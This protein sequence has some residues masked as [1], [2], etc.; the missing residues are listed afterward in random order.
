MPLSGSLSDR[1]FRPFVRW[2]ASRL[3]ADFIR[4]SISAGAVLLATG[5]GLA[6]AE[7]ALLWPLDLDPA[8]SSTF[9]ETR[10]TAFHAGID[11]KTWGRTGFEVRAVASGHV[12]R[13][14]TSPWGF[15]RAVYQKLRDG[16]IAVYAHLESFSPALAQRVRAAQ[17]KAGRYTVDLWLKEGELP[18]AR[19]EVIARSGESGAG[20]PHLHLEIRNAGNVP[21]NPL[22]HDYS[23]ADTKAPTLQ[24]IALVP[25]DHA[26]RVNG[27]PHPVSLQLSPDGAGKFSAP[28]PVRVHG[29]VG[30]AVEGYDRADAAP[31]KLAPL[32]NRLLVDGVERFSARYAS[33]SYADGYQM[34]LDRFRIPSGGALR[35]YFNLFRLPGNRLPFYR[36]KGEAAGIL[37]CG[38][39]PGSGSEPVLEKGPHLLEIESVDAAGNKATARCR[40]LVNADPA[41]LGPRLLA[42]GNQVFAEMEIADAD[43]D[44]VTVSLSLVAGG[45]ARPLVR[46]EVRVGRGPYSFALEEGG[47]GAVWELAASDPG[48]GRDSVIL[49][50]APSA[51]ARLT[52][53]PVQ[54]HGEYVTVAV[55]SGAH[56]SAAPAV[57]LEIRGR[58]ASSRPVP[59]VGEALHLRQS[60]PLEFELTADLRALRGAAA[61][62]MGAPGLFA[63]PVPLLAAAPAHRPS[64]RLEIPLN[65][66]PA[67]P[68]EAVE[69]AFAE[70]A[71]SLRFAATS[72]YGP[73]YPQAAP[74]AATG[75][76]E[77]KSTGPGYAFG[78]V[79]ASFDGH[80]EVTFRVPGDGREPGKLAVYRQ[81]RKGGWGFAGNRLS[82]GSTR[83]G[84]KVR[85]LGRFA[86]L[87]DE[88]APAISGLKPAGGAVLDRSPD[89][90]S[91]RVADHGSGIG[92]ETDLV[93]ELD[94]AGVIFEYDPE[95]G[96]L[97]YRP[98]AD[99]QPGRHVLRVAARDRCGNE[100]EMRA[101]FRVR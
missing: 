97:R 47:P 81:G 23:V 15:G 61:G 86:V 6:A 21:V 28:G 96:M 29:R 13:V 31:N 17:R 45:K 48:G 75:T 87:A 57:S 55:N 64:E 66:R 73:V 78:P 67:V 99:L 82:R 93:M 59:G 37:Q 39:K 30:I 68:G 24:R 36:P 11:L 5:P 2:A 58:G 34:R 88:T 25:M 8:L 83:I 98:E 40:L 3:R 79:L 50:A 90:V 43:D 77:L 14:R 35:T 16:R 65:L 7:P 74:F 53:G 46:Q 63:G 72:A 84:A 1:G 10:S 69:L 100:A 38:G 33:V 26:S 12:T 4:G 94:G 92:S 32:G 95:A 49:T 89:L 62:L 71:V 22:L 56:L 60:G 76:K 91:A 80:V 70:G 20:P 27:R 101:G 42:D 41:I 44:R 52:A 18:V 9:G 19:G 51:S 54:A 85:H